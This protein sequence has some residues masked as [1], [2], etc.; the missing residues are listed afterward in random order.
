[1]AKHPYTTQKVIFT[2][3]P[4]VCNRIPI[5]EWIVIKNIH[6]TTNYLYFKQKYS[7]CFNIVVNIDHTLHTSGKWT[8]L[9][10]NDN[11]YLVSDFTLTCSNATGYN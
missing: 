7:I 9:V 3:Q 4:L 10:I 5:W 1:M 2:L 11:H 8:Q 6:F